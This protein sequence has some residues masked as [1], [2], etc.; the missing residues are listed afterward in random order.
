MQFWEEDDGGENISGGTGEETEVV[1]EQKPAGLDPKAFAQEF[2]EV[3]AKKFQERDNTQQQQQKDRPPT[4]EERAA[5]RKSFGMVDIDDEFLTQ[6]DNLETR[7]SALQKYTDRIY[8]S[9]G[10][11]QAAM[12]AKQ[13]QAWEE[14]FTPVQQM[15][16]Q[17][18]ETERVSRFHKSYPDLA[19]E[20]LQ[21]LISGVGQKLAENGAFKGLSEAKAFD[22]LAKGVESVMKHKNPQ[23]NLTKTTNG[24]SSNE[25]PVESSGGRGGGGQAGVG[26]KPDS[27]NGLFGPVRV[28]K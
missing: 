24:K 21:P 26:V 10:N 15:L 27:P 23:F 14:R 25:I 19:D 3:I 5:A 1:T 18:E 7:K 9:M 2:G 6:F 16:T 17:R 22:V 20:E 4:A 8:E 13:N 12:L 11:I 28:K